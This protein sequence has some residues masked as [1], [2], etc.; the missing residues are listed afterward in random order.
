MKKEKKEIAKLVSRLIEKC[1]EREDS[2]VQGEIRP[3]EGNERMGKRTSTSKKDRK[4]N[5]MLMATV[6][7]QYNT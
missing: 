7:H 5:V 1:T 3:S 6:K 4:K 2:F